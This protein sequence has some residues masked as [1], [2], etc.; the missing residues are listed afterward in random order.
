[1]GKLEI[2]RR[3]L[4]RLEDELEALQVLDVVPGREFGQTI[5][6]YTSKDHQDK[7]FSKMDELKKYREYAEKIERHEENKANGF[8]NGDFELTKNIKYNK[9]S[10]KVI[11]ELIAGYRASE[12]MRESLRTQEKS[13][14]KSQE[15]T[16]EIVKYFFNWEFITTKDIIRCKSRK[17]VFDQALEAGFSKREIRDSIRRGK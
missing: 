10:K 8:R 6:T 12:N 16:A 2:T 13:Q 3:K 17:E 1:M 14:E 11:N 5:H 15:K 4:K 9:C 7:V